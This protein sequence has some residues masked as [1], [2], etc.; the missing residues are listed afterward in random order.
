[1]EYWDIYDKNKQRTGRT[2]EKDSFTLADDEYHLTVLG[3]IMRPDG[4]FLIT[5]R[6]MTKAWAPGWW[7]VSGG[8]CQA[9]EDSKDAVLREVR[10]ETG[11]DVSGWDGGYLFSYKRENPGEGDNYFVDIYRFCADFDEADIH[12]QEEETDGYM[13][14]TFEEVQALAAQGIFLHYDS[15]KRAFEWS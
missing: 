7:E 14:A 3:V 12:L 6:V 1:M 15:I 2:M 11:L 13:L 10:E 4:R 8:A 9:G 5:K